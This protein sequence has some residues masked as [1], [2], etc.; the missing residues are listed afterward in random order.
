V[1]P[2]VIRRPRS[3]ALAA[4]ALLLVAWSLFGFVQDQRS[5]GAA[6]RFARRFTLDR[7]RPLEVAAMGLERS[8]DGAAAVAVDAALEDARGSGPPIDIEPEARALWVQAALGLGVELELARD[9]M[10]DAV[11]YRPASAR[12]RFLLGS[13]VYAAQARSLAGDPRQWIEPLT[14][15]ASAAPGLDPIFSQMGG[16]YLESWPRLS[17]GQRKGAALAWQ[18]AFADPGFVARALLPAGA[19]LGREQAVRLVPEQASS[20]RAAFDALARDG[21]VARAAALRPRLE[22]ALREDRDLGIA[23]IRQRLASGDL[24]GARSLCQEWLTRSPAGEFDDPSGR[25][26]TA[27]VLELWPSDTGGAWRTDPRGELVRFFLN[28]RETEVRGDAL[29]RAT[30]A[31]TGVPDTVRA[32]VRFLAGDPAGADDVLQKSGRPGSFEWVPYLVEVARVKLAAGDAGGAR[33]VLKGLSPSVTDGC[34][35]LLLRRDVAA[36]LGDEAEAAVV[37]ERLRWLRRDSFPAEAWSAAGSMSLCLDDKF[38]RGRKL[39]I[40]IDAAAPAILSFG[41]NGG[42]EGSVLVPKGPSTVTLP[43]PPLSGRQTLSV[44]SEAGGAISV[45]SA[46]IGTGG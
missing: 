23:K 19:I 43:L 25:A 26:Q 1:D 40:S 8:P 27:R 9:L 35:V 11:G 33:V 17:P 38:P 32:R 2:L 24:E 15:A 34:D 31:L 20:L 45:G 21:D 30:D 36:A 37:E 18:R 7:R 14:L 46:S 6:E 4:V 44:S 42:R 5:R 41:W 3:T 22:R 12:D 16:A 29:L 10:L 28:R 39:R 13:V